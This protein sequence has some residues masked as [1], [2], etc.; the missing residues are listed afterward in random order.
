VVTR[1]GRP[2]AVLMALDEEAFQEWALENAPAFV[3]TAERQYGAKT[4]T[5]AELRPSRRRHDASQQGAAT[6]SAA[7]GQA[8]A[9]TT[10]KGGRT[11]SKASTYVARSERRS[12][13]RGRAQKP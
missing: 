9:T 4:G 5:L 2:I 6:G 11:S 1:H 8:A 3:R 13:A 7:P 10:G 12:V